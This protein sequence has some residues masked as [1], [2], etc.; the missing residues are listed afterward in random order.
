[1]IVGLSS[2]L[3]CKIEGLE[4]LTLLQ[5][6]LNLALEFPLLRLGLVCPDILLVPLLLNVIFACTKLCDLSLGLGIEV[7]ILCLLLLRH[8]T[9]KD[10][11]VLLY[12]CFVKHLYGVLVLLLKDRNEALLDLGV[13]I[14]DFICL[15]QV[16]LRL[17]LLAYGRKVLLL[18]ALVCLLR[19]VDP[20]AHSVL[21][22]GKLLPLIDRCVIARGHSIGRDPEPFRRCCRDTSLDL[23]LSWL[24][25]LRCA[26]H[27]IRRCRSHSL[28]LGL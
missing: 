11:T 25:S 10:G 9:F 24:I 2:L 16:L 1:M 22:A 18:L 3:L 20:D 13:Y 27:G 23:F 15:A 12:L 7:S 14:G 26:Q 21:M 4:V 28:T 17:P 6:L 5:K 19:L 8:L